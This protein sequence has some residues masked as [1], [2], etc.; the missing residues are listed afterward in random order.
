MR[1][2]TTSKKSTQ[3]IGLGKWLLLLFVIIV[4]CVLVILYKKQYV[5]CMSGEFVMCIQS[6]KYVSSNK[7]FSFRYPKDYPISF[8]S[9]SEEW[10]NF[11]EVFYPNAGGERLGSVTVGEEAEFKNIKEY[12]N[13]ELSD[14]EKLPER[15][16]GTPPQIEYLDIGGEEAV[17][18]FRNQQPA[19]F[20]PPSDKYVIIRNGKIYKI[21]FDYNDYYHKLPV[22]YY[23][24]AKEVILSTFSFIDSNY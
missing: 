11:S 8:K 20:D 23:N 7:G 16:K 6:K 21:S 13:K 2:R 17:R 10:V 5:N 18:I 22:E 14:F 15:Y 19:S 1:E 24:N 3:K 4:V 12:G 9:G